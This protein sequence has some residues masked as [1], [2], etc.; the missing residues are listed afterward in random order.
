MC[1]CIP[2]MNA[3]LAPY[4]SALVFNL[5]GEPRTVVETYKLN[6]KIRKKPPILQATF[7]PFCG[8]RY[9]KE[10]D[11]TAQAI[12][13]EGQDPQGLGAKPESAVANGDAPGGLRDV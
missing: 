11:V 4:N 6:D 10:S 12:V 5:I 1:G 7:C 8:E 13:T 3:V 9:S 2:E